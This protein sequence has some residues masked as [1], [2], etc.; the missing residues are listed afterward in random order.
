MSVVV[1]PSRPS[2]VGTLTVRRALPNRGR[3]TVGAWCFA[4]HM[5]PVEVTEEQGVDIG[6]HPHTGLQTVTWLVAG[7]IVHHDSLGSEQPIRAGQLNLMTAGHG[8]SHSEERTGSYRGALHGIQLWIAQPEATR[9]GDAAFEHHAELPKQAL[10]S[11]TATVLVGELDGA[12][13]PARRDSDLVGAELALRAGRSTLPLHADWEY[14]LVVLQGAVTIDGTRVVP[15]HLGFLGAGRDEG[16]LDAEGDA[17]ALLIG[18]HAVR[19]A[20]RHVVELR[21]PHAR[22]DLRGPEAV[23]GRRRAVRHRRLDDAADPRRAAA[24]GALRRVATGRRG[25]SAAPAWSTSATAWASCWRGVGHGE[26]RLEDEPAEPARRVTT[27]GSWRR[28]SGSPHRSVSHAVRAPPHRAV[29]VDH[30]EDLVVRRGWPRSGT[31]PARAAASALTPSP[32]ARSRRPRP[33]PRAR[34]GPAGSRGRGAPVRPPPVPSAPAPPA[35]PRRGRRPAAA[36]P[37][38]R[39]RSS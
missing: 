22:R 12:A 33:R 23:D 11:G 34:R 25:E 28:R 6:P 38:R 29:P 15:G 13:S 20:D 4:D 5:G 7:E 39:R 27:P 16:A 14:A 2:E 18:G 1:T 32:R 37:S 9:H 24:L 21:R 31:P 3:R 26:R 35:R 19:G 30:R 17:T 8:V 10:D 36:R